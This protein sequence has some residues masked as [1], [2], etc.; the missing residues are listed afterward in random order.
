MTDVEFRRIYS[1]IKSRYGINMEHKKEIMQGR[2]DNY[3]AREGYSN[4][5]DYMNAV[6]SDITGRLEK[7]LVNILSTNHTFFMREFEHFEFLRQVVLPE[8]KMKEQRTKDLCIWCG[9]ASTGQEPYT[10]AM[11]LKDF[12]GLEQGQ[13][14]TKILATDISTEVLEQAVAGRYSC[15]QAMALPDNW[16]RRY[17]KSVGNG[18]E[19]EIT[20]EIKD[21]VIFRQL[22]LMNDFPF[23]R[24]MHIVFLRNVMIYFDKET[25]RDLINRVYDIMEPGGYLFIGRTEAIDRNHTDFK[26][27]QPSIFR[28]EEGENAACAR[29]AY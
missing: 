12:F 11:L 2:L 14:D 16:K 21:E 29:Y 26:L 17:M 10:L 6:E 9:A 8:L 24:K 3:I 18:G 27:V 7:E 23:K 22:N 19:Y 13:W 25:K 5:S 15:E 1:F 28:K 20:Q 4:Y